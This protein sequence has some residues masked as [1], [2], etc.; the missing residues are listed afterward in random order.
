MSYRYCLEIGSNDILSRPATQRLIS[1]FL[2][3]IVIALAC[4][5]NYIDYID[6]GLLKAMMTHKTFLKVENFILGIIYSS[7]SQPKR[8][9]TSDL[10]LNIEMPCTHSR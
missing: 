7:S 2:I 6:L 9:K 1:N 3:A 5:Q 10:E 4:I 8:V